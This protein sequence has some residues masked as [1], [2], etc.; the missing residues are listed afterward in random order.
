MTSTKSDCDK[1]K[2][3][4]IEV[5][6]WLEKQSAVKEES[7]TDWLL[8]DV[9][10]R[11]SRIRYKTFSR[12]DE[13]RNTGADWEWWFLFPAFSA[14][15]RIQAKKIAGKTDVYPIIAY[16]NR[17]GLQIE[18]LLQDSKTKGFVPFYAL[19]TS[20][21]ERVM[22][23]KAISD[24][25]VY[26]AGGNRIYT[27]FIMNGRK[28]LRESDV[29]LDSVPLSCFL[30]C[31]YCRRDSDGSIVFL[32]HYFFSDI[33]FGTREE[34]VDAQQQ[35]IPGIYRE[36]PDYVSSFMQYPQGEFPDWWE[37]EFE[38]DLEDFNALVVYDARRE[39]TG[40]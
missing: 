19:Y 12:Y 32:K 34:A 5:K 17:Y 15:T 36:I 39:I 9:S 23:K 6:R 20:S 24:E 1:L 33:G 22:C 27:D 16:T 11:I 30:C 35:A 10:R 38:H 8:Y 21:R 2:E 18:K 7:I 4:S 37:G 13:A 40:S 25:G 14:R 29:L 3:S 26:L 31:P 28:A